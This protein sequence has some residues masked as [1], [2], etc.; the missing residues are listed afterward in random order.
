MSVQSTHRVA[1][2]YSCNGLTKQF[3]F[4]FKVFSADEVVA[5]LSDADGVESTLMWGTDYTVALNDNQNANPG[6]S[7]TTRQVY[8]AGYRVTLTSGVTNTQPQTLTNQGGFTPK[9]WRMRW[10]AKR[11][12]CNSWPSKWGDLS[13]WG[14]PMSANQKSCWRLF[15]TACVRRKI[16]PQRRKVL[17]E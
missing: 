3:P 2:P 1:G 6:G 4:D 7:L 10:I 17:G 8:G 13:R 15:L 11:S 16:A 12:S 14:F 5:I 9:C